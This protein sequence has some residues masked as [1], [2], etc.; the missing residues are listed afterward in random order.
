MEVGAAFVQAEEVE[1]IFM[2]P[3]ERVQKVV[4]DFFKEGW[5][6]DPVTTIPLVGLGEE[7]GLG[8][9]QGA[10]EEGEGTLGEEAVKTWV[11]PVGVGV[12]HSMLETTKRMIV[13]TTL[14]VMV[15]WR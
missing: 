1:R 12:D 4:R 7:V 13:V 3:L 2:E 5:V 10:E 15:K 8:D 11:I 9:G 6:G 14:Q